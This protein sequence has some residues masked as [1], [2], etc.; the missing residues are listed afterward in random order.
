MPVTVGLYDGHDAGFSSHLPHCFEVV[1]EG[2]M[3]D[4]DPG[5]HWKSG[6]VM[7]HHGI[8]GQVKT[9]EKLKRKKI[10]EYSMTPF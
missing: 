4:L 2:R 6:W 3:I 9:E 7:R 8:M 1:P 5:A 10:K